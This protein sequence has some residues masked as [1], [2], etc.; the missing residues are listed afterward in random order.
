MERLGQAVENELASVKDWGFAES[1]K[2]ATPYIWI[3]F[4]FDE[5]KTDADQPIGIRA[6]LYLTDANMDNVLERLGNLGWH[7][8]SIMELD[9]TS[10]PFVSI[11]GHKALLTCKMDT[12]EGNTRAKVE[13]INDPDRPPMKPIEKTVLKGLDAKLKGKI[14]AYRQKNPAPNPGSTKRVPVDK[15]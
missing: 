5:L 8:K 7:G 9:K 6:F 11:E 14:A 3:D 10:E 1:G 13:F 4:V 15:D 12:F 2:K